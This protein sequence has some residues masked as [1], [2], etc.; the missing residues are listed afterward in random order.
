MTYLRH[1]ILLLFSAYFTACSSNALS[2]AKQ[3]VAQADSVWAEGGMYNDS[4]SLAQA[5]E[6]LGHLSPFSFLISHSFE[7]LFHLS[8]AYVHACYHYG[9][10]LRAKDDPVAA[11]QVFINATHSG[12]DDKHIL[13]RIYSNMGDICHW[14][15]DFSWS[16]NMFERSADMFLQCGDS[17][18]YYHALNEMAFEK[19]MQAD[20][21]GTETLTYYIKCNCTNP[22]VLERIFETK[23]ELFLRTQQ[24]DSAIYYVNQLFEKG[25]FESTGI[26]IKAQAYSYLSNKDSAVYYA[27]QVLNHSSDLSD[28]HNA[29]YIL[30]NDDE[31]KD[32]EFVRKT[33]ADRSDLQQILR[34]QQGEL[35]QAV[36]LLEQDIN[37]KPSLTWLYA[38][39]ITLLFIGTGIFIYVHKK[40]KRHQLLSQQIEELESKNQDTLS[41]R[42]KQIEAK[43]MML[44]N[45][46]NIKETLCWNDFDKACVIIDQHFNMLA[47]K[48]LQKHILNE[49]EIRLCFLVLLNQSRVQIAETLPYALSG[50]GKLKDQSAKRLGTT[51]KNL[52]DYLLNLALEG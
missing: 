44:A 39:L 37:K 2:E 14:A 30:T 36:Q 11:M 38:I 23:A 46:S 35:S 52:H 17:L 34:K 15:E 49:T 27:E 6:T 29:L 21:Q 31:R 28:M 12:S 24:Y 33:A 1:I 50:I 40:K 45:S 26:L 20:K 19:A 42:R 41:Q 18:L 22:D 4:L 51:G 48:L 16:Y 10:L 5:Y 32:V 13:G 9:K 25:Y 7:R 8:P 43:C 47:S 3:T